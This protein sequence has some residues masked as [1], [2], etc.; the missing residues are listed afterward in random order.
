MN[1]QAHIFEYFN[2]I[3]F[4]TF[5]AESCTLV[6]AFWSP[7]LRMQCITFQ[8]GPEI[9]VRLQWRREYTCYIRNIIWHRVDGSILQVNDLQN[10]RQCSCAAFSSPSFNPRVF[11]QKGPS[12][13]LVGFDVVNQMAQSSLPTLRVKDSVSQ[14]FRCLHR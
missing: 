14:K 12:L 11:L 2:F 10:L 5:W 9:D 4:K 3:I 13:D 6:M 1:W 7:M 8:Q